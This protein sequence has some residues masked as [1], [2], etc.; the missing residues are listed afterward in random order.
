MMTPTIGDRVHYV[1]NEGRSLGEHR[2]AIIVRVWGDRE[3][4]LV[5]LQVITDDINDKLPPMVWK[6]SVKQ[7]DDP[8]PGT[9]HEKEGTRV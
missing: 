1:L 8:T 6:T 5:N 9:W 3:D 2:P 7:S 4:S